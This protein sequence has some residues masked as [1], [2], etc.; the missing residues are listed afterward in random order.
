MSIASLKKAV[1]GALVISFS[2]H[3]LSASAKDF[4]EREFRSQPLG[5]GVYELRALI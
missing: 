5:H 2:L 1:R 4:S 3:A